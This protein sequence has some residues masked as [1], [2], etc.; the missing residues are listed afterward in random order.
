MTNKE[1]W[2]LYNTLVMGALNVLG[3]YLL[4][5]KLGMLGAGI[6]TASALALWNLAAVIEVYWFFRIRAFSLRYIKVLGV[7]LG[8]MASARALVVVVEGFWSGVLGSVLGLVLFLGYLWLQ[9]LSP[10]D[11]PVYQAVAA[12]LQGLGLRARG[13]RE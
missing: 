12:R 3:N 4:V 11:E 8:V 1:R 6:S 5:P 13:S 10:E 9:G 7:G 2:V